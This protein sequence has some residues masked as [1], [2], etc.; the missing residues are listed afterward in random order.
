MFAGQEGL[1]VD[2]SAGEERERRKTTVEESERAWA[3]RAKGE[4]EAKKK[5]RKRFKDCTQGRSKLAMIQGSHSIE[6]SQKEKIPGKV[7]KREK[8]PKET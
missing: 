5:L 6:E 3:A 7:G 8:K 2:N 1:S 4:E